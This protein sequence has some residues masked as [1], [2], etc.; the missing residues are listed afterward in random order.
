MQA[1]GPDFK[2]HPHLKLSGMFCF[3]R[4]KFVYRHLAQALSPAFSQQA[5]QEVGGQARAEQEISSP[6]IF[7]AESCQERVVPQTATQA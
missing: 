2:S 7:G 3:P 6:P 5:Q 4:F 1:P